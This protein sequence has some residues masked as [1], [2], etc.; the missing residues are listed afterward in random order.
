MFHTIHFRLKSVKRSNPVPAG[1]SGRILERNPA[2]PVPAGFGNFKSGATL[3]C[4]R[5]TIYFCTI[6]LS[7]LYTKACTNGLQWKALQINVWEPA[8]F[9]AVSFL[10]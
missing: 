5:V 3:V 4:M 9:I 10:N 2:N 8:D 1:E 6:L 7:T